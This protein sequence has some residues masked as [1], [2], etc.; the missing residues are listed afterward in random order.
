MG[1]LGSGEG[2]KGQE[3]VKCGDRG[4]G[5]VCSKV[6][7]RSWRTRR[8]LYSS[9]LTGI[10]GR[11]RALDVRGDVRYRIARVHTTFKEHI[12]ILKDGCGGQ[13]SGCH[14]V[15]PTDRDRF[16]DRGGTRAEEKKKNWRAFFYRGASSGGTMD[17]CIPFPV[18]PEEQRA[19]GCGAA[20]VASRRRDSVCA[21]RRSAR[22]PDG[23]A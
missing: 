17:L 2:G 23:S 12:Q 16:D 15:G 13:C 5:E 18:F 21:C 1:T 20:S 11:S 19:T 4:W 3:R 22:A 10:H 6:V 14:T 9:R 8:A 7:A